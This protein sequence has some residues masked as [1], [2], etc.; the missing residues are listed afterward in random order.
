MGILNVSFAVLMFFRLHISIFSSKYIL[1]EGVVVG[2]AVV[3]GAAVVAFAADVTGA[4]VEAGAAEVTDAAVVAGADVV[5]GAAV[6]FCVV[7]AASVDMPAGCV[8]IGAWVTG[9]AVVVGTAV[10]AGKMMIKSYVK[11]MS[12]FKKS[13]SDKVQIFK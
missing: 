2:G 7:W 6:P 8:V 4:A 9:W 5:T 13:S 10:V 3:T 1:R 12:A 11:T